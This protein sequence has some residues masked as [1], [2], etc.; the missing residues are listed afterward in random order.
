MLQQPERADELAREVNIYSRL[1]PPEIRTEAL[2]RT[3]REIQDSLYEGV[4]QQIQKE[5][6]KEEAARNG[7]TN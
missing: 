3:H 2:K 4:S 5:R 6:M 1:L 7:E